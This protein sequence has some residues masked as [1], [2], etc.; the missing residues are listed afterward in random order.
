MRTVSRP[1]LLARSS[2]GLLV[3][4]ALLEVPWAFAAPMWPKIVALALALSLGFWS[5]PRGSGSGL[6]RPVVGVLAAGVGLFVVAA[7]AGPAPLAG[8]LGRWPR[9]EGLPV[10]LLYAAAV[11]LGARLLGDRGP[12]GTWHSLHTS[13]SW[14]SLTLAAAAG[15]EAAGLRPFGGQPGVRPGVTFL[16]ASEQALWGLL[17]AGLLLAPAVVAG[18]RP[19]LR[20]GA[21]SAV[22]LVL[23]SGSRAGLAGLGLV[24]V[25]VAL[26]V[27]AGRRAGAATGSAAARARRPA[28]RA[29]STP[30]WSRRG[31]LGF[32]GLL[33][34]GMLALAVPAVRSRLTDADTISGRWL[35]W[36]QTGRLV[37]DHPVLGVGPSGFVDAITA[38]HDDRYAVQ[39]GVDS[40]IDSAHCWA[41]QAAAALGL[42]GALLALGAAALVAQ[43]CWRLRAPRDEAGIRLWG[44][45][46]GLVGYGAALL[47]HFT[48]PQ[49]TPLAALLVGAVLAERSGRSSGLPG[50][51]SRALWVAG[52]GGCLLWS[53]SALVGDL[54][55][56]AGAAAAARGD[57]T[58][59]T[60]SFDSAAGWRPLDSEVPLLAAQALG[61]RAAD[62]D[63][64]AAAACLLWSDRALDRL[65]ASGEARLTRAVALNGLGRS[66]EAL[67]TLDES[68][69]RQPSNYLLLVQ[70]G[71]A[72]AQLGRPREAVADL[73]GAARLAPRSPVPWQVLARVYLLTGDTAA[74]QR[75]SREAQVRAGPP[76]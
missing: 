33:G 47:T 49:T 53:L 30:T 26:A 37:L 63:P 18:A 36:Q 35:L 65:P 1:W 12:A 24:V 71:I 16:N 46:A 21:G 66:A 62:G 55:L 32:G 73:T 17:V 31:L 19:L 27:P 38:Y 42:P 69:A 61:A 56:G 7:L 70:R 45:A 48:S 25:L 3:A 5:C 75:A 51:W 14:V 39:V 29:A 60:H 67:A 58:G 23:T 68:I 74:A 11:V 59:A 40:V 2:L 8:L 34:V 72:Q 22:L 13:V 6:P 41:L 20:W 10:L 64:A 76:G 28:A 9:F 50:R 52:C 44:A 15:L 43:A 4:A 57:L 54:A